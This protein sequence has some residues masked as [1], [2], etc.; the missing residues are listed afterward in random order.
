M[1][2]MLLLKV[3]TGR[4]CMGFISTTSTL[5]RRL[6]SSQEH[7]HQQCSSHGLVK[8]SRH[9]GV[10][11]SGSLR[12]LMS[13]LLMIMFIV[14]L[15][16]RLFITSLYTLHTPF[17]TWKTSTTT[18]SYLM[19]QIGPSSK[20]TFTSTPSLMKRIITIRWVMPLRMPFKLSSKHQLRWKYLKKHVRLYM[21]KTQIRS[22][23]KLIYS[24]IQTRKRFELE[25]KAGS[26]VLRQLKQRLG[27]RR[28]ALKSMHLT[29][30]PTLKLMTK[31]TSFSKVRLGMRIDLLF[32]S[33]FIIAALRKELLVLQ[34]R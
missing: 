18:S 21:E 11:D 12:C 23:F 34:S 33:E 30:L 1:V 4:L 15:M 28:K 17:L 29:M 10:C 2:I 20:F 9:E 13:S 25:E 14:H 24:I 3:I 32:T 7:T 22:S 27:H 26:M 19:S 6:I 5:G 16:K 31:L 8:S